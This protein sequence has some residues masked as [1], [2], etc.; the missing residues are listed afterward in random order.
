MPGFYWLR[1]KLSQLWDVSGRPEDSQARPL[2]MGGAVVYSLVLIAA[3]LVALIPM[4]LWQAV[5]R[6]RAE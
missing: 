6:R 4:V 5:H 2:I 3:W 1:E